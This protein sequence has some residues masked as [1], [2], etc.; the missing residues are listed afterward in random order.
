[1]TPQHVPVLVDEI[2]HLLCQT[3]AFIVVD[4]TAGE[5][6]HTVRMAEHMAPGGILLAVDRDPK[7]LPFLEE[8][9]RDLGC[10]R[11]RRGLYQ[12]LPDLLTRESLCSADFVLLDLGLSSFQLADQERGFS[13]SGDQPCDMRMSPEC[14]QTAAD[15]LN[16]CREDELADILYAWG[17][18]PRSRR[19][20][21]EL[22]KERKRAPI[23]TTQ[24]VVD[25][26]FRASG[27]SRSRIHPATRTFQALRC[28]VNREGQGL[29]DALERIPPL[30]SKGGILAV[31]S[32][33]SLEDGR[34]KRSFR[35][36]SE[37]GYETLCRK[38]IRPDLKEIRTNR[39]AR[40]ARLRALL[41]APD[42][43]QGVTP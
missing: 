2:L 4:G 8:R 6:G 41:R 9:T 14:E 1:M 15:L 21:A 22:V 39:R 7:V 43:T 32:Y 30:L 3:K 38:P 27:R 10:V 23:Q 20:A 36:W 11:A 24:Q 25:A 35:S 42:S 19:I 29:D 33:H 13:F 40:S 34:V 31:I 18:E 17:E 5:G 12:E 37:K 26:V 28:F 16:G